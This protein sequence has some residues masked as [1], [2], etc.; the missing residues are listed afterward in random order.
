MAA[1]KEVAVYDDMAA[2]EQVEAREAAGGQHRQ[3]LVK[4][5][6]EVL[7]HVLLPVLF[8]SSFCKPRL[9]EVLRVHQLRICTLHT[10]QGQSGANSAHR[11]AGS[12]TKSIT[13]LR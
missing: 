12:I 2:R 4:S 6:F 11:T 5:L 1:C 7:W 8:Q 3:Q 10:L 9:N 13:K